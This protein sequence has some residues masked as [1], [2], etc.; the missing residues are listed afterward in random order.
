[1][2]VL[3]IVC[4]EWKN[5]SRDKRELMVCQ[6]LGASV[7]VLAKGTANA[8]VVREN[9]DDFT[10]Y[11]CTTRPVLLFP[12]SVNRILSLAR[13]ALFARKINPDIISGHD[14]LGVFV[15]LLSNVAKKKKAKLIYDAH[16]FELGRWGSHGFIRRFFI[17]CIE[18][19][20]IK[21]CEFTITVSKGIA[22]EEIK[23]YGSNNTI[24]TVR[25]TPNNWVLDDRIAATRNRIT[26]EMDWPQDAFVIMYHGI[27]SKSRNISILI[28]AIERNPNTY[29]IILGD[30]F[31]GTLGELKEY[32]EKK[33]FANRAYFHEAVPIESLYQYV[34]MSDIG[35]IMGDVNCVSHLLALPNKLF[36]NIQ[37]LTPIIASNC[38]EM[39]SLI[40]DYQVGITVDPSNEEEI[41]RAIEKFRTDKEF[42]NRIKDNLRIAKQDLCWENEKIIL[43]EAYSEVMEKLK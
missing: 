27:I 33:G 11:K 20:I 15:G 34:G 30:G 13:W 3:K 9:V 32:C 23:L 21:K 7:C 22:A 29:G 10:I 14:M 31:D 16:E 5:E 37:S 4:S 39:K 8:K 40:D 38:P 17:R 36:E 6:E 25:S 28:K 1:M 42:Y 41:D 43:K 2:Q 24:I 19:F 35:M 18:G 12:T 26:R